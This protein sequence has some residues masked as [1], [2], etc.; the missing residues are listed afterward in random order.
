MTALCLKCDG[1][2]IIRMDE[3]GD[4]LRTKGGTVKVSK[5]LSSMGVPYAPVVC[6]REKPVAVFASCLGGVNR[7]S[8]DLM[9]SD[10]MEKPRMDVIWSPLT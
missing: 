6:D 1:S 9:T 4:V 7:I 10:W 5:L 3:D 2:L 8:S